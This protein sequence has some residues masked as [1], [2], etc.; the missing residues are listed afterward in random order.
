MTPTPYYQDQHVTLYHGDCVAGMQQLEAKHD[1][2]LTDPPYFRVKNEPWDRQWKNEALFFGWLGGVLDTAKPLMHPHASI[3]VFASP[4]LSSKVELLASERYRVLNNI[5]W[6]KEAGWHRKAKPENLRAFQ[7][8]WESIIFAE[9]YD[10][11][12]GDASKALHREVFAPIGRYLQGEWERA[13][14]K[15]GKVGV[16]LG[17]DSALPTRWAEGSSLPSQE[18][19]ERLRVL[20]NG[21]QTGQYLN[22]EYEHLRS[23]YEHLRRE[24]EHLRRPF[25]LTAST[26]NT[27]LWTYP[28]VKPRAG[29]HPCEKPQEMLHHMIETSTRPGAVILD[30]FAG[31]GSTLFAAKTMGRSA[32]GFEMNEKYC[33]T[34]AQRLSQGALD[35]NI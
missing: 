2:L 8:P 31:S 21:D 25:N 19:Y 29:K 5:R 17:Y 11:Q 1:A 3:W 28:V 10:D 33:E 34:I 23:E 4:E 18:A 15:A 14:W 26:L 20:L 6:Y 35:L 27:D 24:Y 13:G 16:G 32:V 7:R 9:Q 12:Y 22:R 30:P